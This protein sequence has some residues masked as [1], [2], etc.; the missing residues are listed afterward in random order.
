MILV[1][2][3]MWFIHGSTV[4]VN[5]SHPCFNVLFGVSIISFCS[6]VILHGYTGYFKE[7]EDV[8]SPALKRFSY[9]ILAACIYFLVASSFVL[10]KFIGCNSKAVSIAVRIG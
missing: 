5:H 7:K 2:N 6:S 8:R 4:R 10:I 9:I 1:V 3:E